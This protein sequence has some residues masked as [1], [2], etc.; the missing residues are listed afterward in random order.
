MSHLNRSKKDQSPLFLESSGAQYCNVPFAP[1]VVD[2][3]SEDFKDFATP[4]SITQ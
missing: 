3:K 1:V 2:L 4:K